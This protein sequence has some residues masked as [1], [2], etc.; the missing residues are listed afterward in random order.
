MT[1]ATPNHAQ[2]LSDTIRA[3][4]RSDL[5][6][7]G[8]PKLVRRPP[9]HCL[10]VTDTRSMFVKLTP[11]DP[12]VEAA[13]ARHAASNG[14]PTPRLLAR[15]RQIDDNWWATP[16]KWLPADT[17]NETP[18]PADVAT[19]MGRIWSATPPNPVRDMP[20]DAYEAQA[21]ANIARHGTP[22][23]LQAVLDRLIDTTMNAVRQ[24]LADHQPTLRTT[25]THG[26]LHE[27]NLVISKGRLHVIDWERHGLS[28][29]ENE[30]AKYLQ[31][32]LSEQQ[33]T[34]AAE[35]AAAAGETFLSQMEALG[36]DTV[37]VW[38]L[39]GLRAAGAAAYLAN[40]D[41]RARHADWLAQTVDLANRAAFTSPDAG[42]QSAT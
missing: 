35:T 18:S 29:P 19:I 9:S 27:R 22:I 7:T 30:A 11:T 24:H 10:F 36:L 15:P 16:Y 4:R 20:W 26:D 12:A 1:I 13:G 28:L 40:P 5:R 39:T 23:A 34:N 37:L 21:R 41:N 32:L 3:L 17:T 14:I 25:W 33:P 2:L 42:R 8:T 38:R 31:T 6:F